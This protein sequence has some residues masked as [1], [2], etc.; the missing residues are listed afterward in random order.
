MIATALPLI[1]GALLVVARGGRVGLFE[2][3]VLIGAGI[4]FAALGRFAKEHF[5]WAMLVAAAA[6]F[7]GFAVGGGIPRVLADPLLWSVA[8]A[9]GAYAANVALAIRPPVHAPMVFRVLNTMVLVVL[10]VPVVAGQV[11][12]AIVILP[13]AVFRIAMTRAD[14]LARSDVIDREPVLDLS[15]KIYWISGGWIAAWISVLP[16]S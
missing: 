10:V 8:F 4:V 6:V 15:R 2:G 11:H 16:S 5:L 13:F 1:A 14:E 7:A 3:A 9:Y 12:W